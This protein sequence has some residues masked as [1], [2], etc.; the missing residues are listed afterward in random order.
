[1]EQVVRVQAVRLL[2]ACRQLVRIPAAPAMRLV[3]IL[4]VQ[5]VAVQLAHLV[6][7]KQAV[8]QQVQAKMA[9]GAA[10][11]AVYEHRL[12]VQAFKQ[13]QEE[14]AVTVRME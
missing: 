5:V 13:L 10:V 9:A 4:I 8:H 3:I 2:V 12:A 6:M 14:P 11:L 7:D 1:M